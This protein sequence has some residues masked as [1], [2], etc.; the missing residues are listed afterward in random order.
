[1]A[2]LRTADMLT[3]E[4]AVEIRIL[5]RQGESI[6]QISRRT[7]LSRNTVRRYLRDGAAQRYGPRAP[8]PCKLDPYLE[9]LQARIAQARPDWIPA[10]VLLREL[11]ELGYSGGISQLKAY[12]APFKQPLPEPVI[13]FETAPGQQLQVDFTTVRRGRSRLLAFVATLGFS[14]ATFVRFATREDFPAWREGLLAAF[15][16]FGGVPWEVLFDNAKPVVIERD[17]YGPG[18]HRWHPG[19]L[20]LA[21]HCGFKLRLC[22]PYRARTKG[23]VERFNGYLKGSFL[24][25]LAASLRAGGLALDTD[26]A[27]REVRRW[28]DTVANRRLHGTTGIEP[29]R[30][31]PEDQAR[32]LPLPQALTRQVPVMPARTATTALP[33]ESLQHPLSVYQSLLEAAA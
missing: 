30:R 8:R 33:V 6:R 29:C 31:L 5:A 19:M 26:L 11:H 18:R 23:K 7:G 32:L 10:T 21:Q 9:H 1:M 24:V 14:R 13:R 15:E 28:L 25:P 3:Q 4:Q 27:N 17:L 16:Y 2:V 20:D 12:L 22:R